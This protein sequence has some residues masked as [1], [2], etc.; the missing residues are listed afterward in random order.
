MSDF[1]VNDKTFFLSGSTIF[2]TD[3]E[4]TNGTEVTFEWFINQKEVDIIHM[5]NISYE[6]SGSHTYMKDKGWIDA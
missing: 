1:K 4:K 2:Y 6:V 3:S 5:L